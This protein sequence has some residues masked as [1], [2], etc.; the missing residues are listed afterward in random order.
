[1]YLFRPV[2]I[3]HVP[4]T[5]C[6]PLPLCPHCPCTPSALF[7]IGQ[8]PTWVIGAQGVCGTRG[9]GNGAY[10]QRRHRAM[11]YRGMW[12]M[13]S[14][15]QGT[16]GYRGMCHMGNEVH[17]GYGV[18]GQKLHRGNRV[19]RVWGTQVMGHMGNGANRQ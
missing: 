13:D 15:A 8:W 3:A 9:M 10:G 16:M 14:G 17:M 2:L 19:Q 1:M 12:H 4:H 18:K 5:H 11:G 6:T 7:Q